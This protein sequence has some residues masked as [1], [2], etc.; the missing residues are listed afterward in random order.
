MRTIS[1]ILSKETLL[2]YFL[3][4]LSL[5]RFE[6]SMHTIIFLLFKDHGF[7]QDACPDP[8][9]ARSKSK[10]QNNSNSK[11]SGCEFS[12]VQT[13]NTGLNYEGFLKMLNIELIF[14]LLVF[15]SSSTQN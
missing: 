4:S 10:C 12:D 1:P 3:K 6:L 11:C 15:A 9:S 5:P 2:N 13:F 14:K 8:K 7:N